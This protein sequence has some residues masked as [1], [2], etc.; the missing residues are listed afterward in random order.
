MCICDGGAAAAAAGLSAR[1]MPRPCPIAS[2]SAP[3]TNDIHLLLLLLLLLLLFPQ[4][5]AVLAERLQQLAQD[6][7]WQPAARAAQLLLW[8]CEHAP[9]ATAALIAARG[10]QRL[11]GA[12]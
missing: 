5:V 2:A 9:G 4:L 10:A 8:L 7:H 11:Q 12:L 3:H 1:C 6:G